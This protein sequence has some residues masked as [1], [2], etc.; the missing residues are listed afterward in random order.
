MGTRVWAR[1]WGLCSWKTS[2]AKVLKWEDL[3]LS[4]DWE[5]GQGKEREGAR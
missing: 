4:Q 1:G 5:G 2:V 3:G